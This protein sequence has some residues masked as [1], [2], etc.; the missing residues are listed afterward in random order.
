MKNLLIYYGWLN[1]FNSA[2]NGWVN[3]KVAQ[4]L[5]KYDLLVFGQGLEDPSH[6]DY[7]NTQTILCRIKALNPHAMI[8]GYVTANQTFA[9]FKVKAGRWDDLGVHG[10]FFDEAGYDYGTVATNGR[11]AFNQKVDYVHSLPDASFC[12]INAWKSE[13]IV[14]SNGDA[15][16]PDSTWN[17][18]GVKSN[19]LYDD[20]YLYESFAITSAEAYESASQWASRV[21]DIPLRKAACSVIADGKTDG[22]ARFKF[23]WV[24]ALMNNLEAV[25]SSDT[26]YGASSAKSQMWARPTPKLPDEKVSIANNG[27]IYYGY[28][29]G[30]RYKLDFTSGSESAGILEY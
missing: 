15:S 17:P 26:N 10:I 1:S 6:G 20:W 9:N 16:Y 22:L 14:G 13:H 11:T 25:G 28:V 8:F 24:S 3:E 18:D 4:E 21:T 29:P 5:A 12:F 27:S 2:S 7:S 23:I 30:G 19:L